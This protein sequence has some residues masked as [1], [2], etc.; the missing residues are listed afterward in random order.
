MPSWSSN[1][2][3]EVRRASSAVRRAIVTGIGSRGASRC[4]AAGLAIGS[5]TGGALALQAQPAL[6]QG[7]KVHLTLPSGKLGG[8]PSGVAVNSAG[9]VWVS[10]WSNNVVYEY[11]PGENAQHET[12]WTRLAEIKSLTCSGAGSLRNPFGISLDSEGNLWVADSGNHRLVELSSSGSCVKTVGVPY[13]E[14]GGPGK[15]TP[16]EFN[17]ATD[18]AENPISKNLL[19]TDMFNQR[20]VELTKSGEYKHE[21]GEPGKWGSGP[22]EFHLPQGL[23]VASNGHVLVSEPFNDRV[24]EVEATSQ[25]GKASYL[26]HVGAEFPESQAVAIGPGGNAWVGDNRS[27]ANDVREFKVPLE[28]EKGHEASPVTTFGFQGQGAEQLEGVNGLTVDSNGNVWVDDRNP[29]RVEEWLVPPSNTVAPSISGTPIEGHTLTA[30][31]TWEGSKPLSVSYTWERC[32]ASNE[33]KTT[34]GTSQTYT[35]GASDIGDK[36]RVTVSASNGEGT[37]GPLQSAETAVATAVPKNTKPPELNLSGEPAH[38]GARLKL[39]SGGNG[40]WTGSPEM[41]FTY[42]WERCGL[43]GYECTAISAATLSEYTLTNQ[44]VGHTVGLQVTGH[45]PAGESSVIGTPAGI[46]EVRPSGEKEYVMSTAS[47]CVNEPEVLNEKGTGTVTVTANGPV[48]S[49]PGEQTK[50]TGGVASL[51]VQSGVTESLRTKGVTQVRGSIS[52][53]LVDFS[54]FEHTSANIAQALGETERSF[55]SPVESGHELTLT[56][57]ASVGTFELAPGKVTATRGSSTTVKLDPA[58][59]FEETS[60]G[61]GHYKA[62]G[63]GVVASFTGYGSKGEQ[64]V[65]PYK[66]VCTAGTGSSARVETAVGKPRNTTAPTMTKVGTADAGLEG[67]ALTANEGSWEGSPTSF[68][69]EWQRCPRLPSEIAACQTITGA[70]AKTYTPVAADVHRT[71]RVVVTATN[72]FGSGSAASARSPSIQPQRGVPFTKTSPWNKALPTNLTGEY[73]DKH[74]AKLVELLDAH[75]NAYSDGADLFEFGVPIWEVGGEANTITCKHPEG[76]ICSIANQRL[77]IPAEAEPTI[78]SDHEMVVLNRS[79]GLGYDFWQAHRIGLTSWETNSDSE[80]GI[81]N[82]EST[83][84]CIKEIEHLKRYES[85]CGATG[86][87]VPQLAGLITVGDL[88][89]GTIEH[90][91]AFATGYTCKEFFREPASKTDGHFGGYEKGECIPEGTRIRLKPSATLGAEATPAEKMVATALKTYGAYC[92]DSTGHEGA[93]PSEL[94]GMGF[95]FEDYGTTP[96]FD[97][98]NPYYTLGLQYDYYGMTNI[99]WSELEVLKDWEGGTKEE[100]LP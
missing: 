41:T 39:N 4:L 64:L 92:R 36:L 44:D 95:A 28:P 70:T 15:G 40:T 62:T 99:P 86:A 80:F 89:S 3:V 71:L 87:G 79:G 9:D 11:E 43:T 12:T 68:T 23:A 24:Q 78:G 13:P 10:V 65:G 84:V 33:C 53:F 5:L 94:E 77:A 31:S 73:L 96:F 54:G 26:G 93:A 30:G 66:Y 14:E 47:E 27:M 56:I 60:P 2:G 67:H 45:D 69:Y 37:S 6:A 8:A 16:V 18:V 59:A 63:N 22:G 48:F 75:K 35:V 57:P 32:N 61:S 88:E 74:D 100:N 76:E 90:A 91:L 97:H 1:G 19:V 81:N 20:V 21:L 42:Q 55:V 72:T 34:G 29:N 50:L 7:P 58:P 17:D 82:T 49:E 25:E 38:V 98:A 46:V 51:T 52:N 85:T 83:G